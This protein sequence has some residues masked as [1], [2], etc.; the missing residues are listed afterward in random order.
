MNNNSSNNIGGNRLT[1]L[2][3]EGVVLFDSAMGTSI[4]AAGALNLGESTGRVNVDAPGVIKDIH[5]RNIEAG[6]DVITT[7]T[8]GSHPGGEG[9]AGDPGAEEEAL[10]AGVRIARKA[11]AE[12]MA[13]G[14]AAGGRRVFTA[15]D[16]GPVGGIIGMTND[17]TH[18]EAIEIFAQTVGIGAGE[19]ADLILIETMA[20]IA[21]A[22][23]AITA[24]RAESDLPVICTMTFDAGGRTFMGVSPDEFV[25]AA[26]EA[27]ADAVGANCSVGPDEMLP[28][29]EAIVKAAGGAPVLVQPNAG[30]PRMGKGAEVYYDVTPEGFADG[31]FKMIEAGAALVG[32][33]CGTTPDMIAY[34]KRRIM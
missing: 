25:K 16:I 4:I 14:G 2:L 12:A 17:M 5:L 18:D 27:G 21:E 24:A 30:Q 3:G 23:D 13:P 6:C 29:A 20:D 34:L 19:G 22:L 10:R 28:I 9:G 32:G 1:A 7:N 31:V 15:L 11:A 8:F 33:C 26:L